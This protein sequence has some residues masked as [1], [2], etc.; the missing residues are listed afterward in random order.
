MVVWVVV[1][2]VPPLGATGESGDAVVVDSSVVVV[3]VE[4]AGM[5]SSLLAQPASA[6]SAREATEEKTKFFMKR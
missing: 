2:E 5:E 4:E 3:V 1:V 6:K